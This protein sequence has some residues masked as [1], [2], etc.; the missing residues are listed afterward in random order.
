MKVLLFLVAAALLALPFSRAD[1]A[2]Y[3]KEQTDFS[4]TTVPLANYKWNHDPQWCIYKEPG[5]PNKSMSG[6]SLLCRTGERR[7]GNTRAA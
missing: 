2:L 7:S 5:V 4:E 1:A 3:Y 6:S